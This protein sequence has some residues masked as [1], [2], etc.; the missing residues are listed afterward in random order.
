[1]NILKRYLKAINMEHMESALQKAMNDLKEINTNVDHEIWEIRRTQ[2]AEE[3]VGEILSHKFP[4][5][6][7]YEEMMASVYALADAYRDSYFET[8]FILGMIIKE[9]EQ[10]K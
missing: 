5:I 8:G 9:N 1:M 3:W 10:L 4:D 2:V 6:H 7:E